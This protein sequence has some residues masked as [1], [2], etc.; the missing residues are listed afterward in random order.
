MPTALVLALGQPFLQGGGWRAAGLQLPGRERPNQGGRK[1]EKHIQLGS[2]IPFY[3]R[4]K[5]TRCSEMLSVQKAWLRFTSAPAPTTCPPASLLCEQGHR[6]T[7]PLGWGGVS[8]PLY[9][10]PGVRML[11]TS[12]GYNSRKFSGSLQLWS[13]ILSSSSAASPPPSSP[14]HSVPLFYLIPGWGRGRTQRCE[15]LCVCG[16]RGSY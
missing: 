16:E 2:N 3:P 8:A 13:R 11:Q 14:F 9:T 1:G 6:V 4:R 5:E 7:E 10:S 15:L 12:K